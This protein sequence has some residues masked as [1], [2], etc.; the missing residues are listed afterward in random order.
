MSGKKANG[1]VKVTGE[2]GATRKG[3]KTSE[4]SK[5]SLFEK[6]KVKLLM[7]VRKV[8]Y[9]EAL[10]IVHTHGNVRDEERTCPKEDERSGSCNLGGGEITVE[11]FFDL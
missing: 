11:E 9:E 5:E 8:S 6:T 2:K 3:R 10:R 7:R 1:G 4:A